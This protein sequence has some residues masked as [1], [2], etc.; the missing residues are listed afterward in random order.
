MDKSH[1]TGAR[2][3]PRSGAMRAQVTL[4]LVQEDAQGSIQGFAVMVEVIA[5]PLGQGQDPLAHRPRGQDMIDKVGRA[6]YHAPGVARRADAPAF[7]REGDQEVMTA[8][9]AAGSRKAV[10]EDSALQVPPQLPLGVRRDALVLPV[11]PAQGKEGLE[12]VLHHPV[13]R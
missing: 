1:R 2:I 4:D 11:I 10:G 8:L 3:R 5:Q 12:M 13:E 9:V 6:F 7:A